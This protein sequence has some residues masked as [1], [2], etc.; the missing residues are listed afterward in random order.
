[1]SRSQ[2]WL[3]GTSPKSSS[4]LSILNSSFDAWPFS[5]SSY[6]G[7]PSA[8]HKAMAS[9]FWSCRPKYVNVVVCDVPGSSLPMIGRMS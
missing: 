1:M 5:S 8:W 7:P 4:V 9:N 3:N 2:I 6:S